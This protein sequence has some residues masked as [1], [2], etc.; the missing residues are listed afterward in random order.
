MTTKP[1]TLRNFCLRRRRLFSDRELDGLGFDP[2]DLRLDEDFLPVESRPDEWLQN[3]DPVSVISILESR[4]YMGNM[5]L[6]DSDVFGMAHGLEIRVPLLDRRVVDPAYSLH[7]TTRVS[8]RG[9]NKRVLVK[10]LGSR[11]RPQLLGLK[12]TGFSVPM[13]AWMKGPLR[14]LVEESLRDLKASGLLE[15]R[16]VETA[17]RGF[18]SREDGTDWSR[19]WLLATIGKWSSARPEAFTSD[20]LERAACLGSAGT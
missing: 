12:K 10:A 20:R 6:R 16:H 4:F 1:R 13:S 3:R 17:W 15:P 9:P 8:R 11:L 18:L 14:E 7:G 5:L 2:Q 19:I